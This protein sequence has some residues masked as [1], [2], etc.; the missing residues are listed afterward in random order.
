MGTDRANTPHRRQ[1]T[2]ARL[3]HHQSA[4]ARATQIVS[5][6]ERVTNA[7]RVGWGWP[8]RDVDMETEALREASAVVN[9]DLRFATLGLVSTIA[10]LDEDDAAVVGTSP[11]DERASPRAKRT[12]D[13][14]DESSDD[15]RL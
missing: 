5:N 6:A 7:Y 11:R 1:C 2:K 9:N 4:Y 15:A 3:H 8:S 12:R 13:D 10:A 14:V